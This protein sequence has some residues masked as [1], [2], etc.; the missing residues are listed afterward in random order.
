MSV[1]Y[2]AVPENYQ[3]SSMDMGL[4]L[5]IPLALLGG[6]ML[7]KG[8]ITAG[9]KLLGK[10]ADKA[11]GVLKGQTRNVTRMTEKELAEEAARQAQWDAALAQSPRPDLAQSRLNQ[12]SMGAPNPAFVGSGGTVVKKPDIPKA[13]KKEVVPDAPAS[14]ADVSVVSPG[15]SASPDTQ[16]LTKNTSQA[17]R[18]SGSQARNQKPAPPQGE[19]VPGPVNAAWKPE[20]QAVGQPFEHYSMARI[21][22]LGSA[23]DSPHLYTGGNLTKGLD[24]TVGVPGI[25]PPPQKSLNLPNTGAPAA[26]QIPQ[27]P[28]AQVNTNQA[29]A[30]QQ[31][32]LQQ[33]GVASV[34]QQ[35][36]TPG[37][38]SQVSDAMQSQNLG[39]MSYSRIQNQ[40]VKSN[41]D[42]GLPEQSSTMHKTSAPSIKIPTPGGGSMPKLKLPSVKQQSA[43]KG[44]NLP[45][46]ST[47]QPSIPNQGGMGGAAQ[48]GSFQIPAAVPQQQMNQITQ[49]PQPQV[50]MPKTA[51]DLGAELLSVFTKERRKRRKRKMQDYLR[52]MA[53]DETLQKAAA[54][55]GI[56][57][58]TGPWMSDDGNVISMPVPDAMLYGREPNPLTEDAQTRIRRI[59]TVE[60]PRDRLTA[61][62][63][64]VARPRAGLWTDKLMND[65]F[66]KNP[67]QDPIP[68]EAGSSAPYSVDQGMQ[69][70]GSSP[71]P[72]QTGYF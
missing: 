23:T 62:N 26:N 18:V 19:T 33:S 16:N 45:N 50:P 6:T 5:G 56:R 60:A 24:N 70:A 51:S 40:A 39:T 59:G 52:K 57:G 68:P 36:K 67:T 25:D 46:Q 14:K 29:V 44:L 34:G 1:D 30:V 3:G 42:Q 13:P 58:N 31:K 2:S 55:Y 48:A 41:M 37:A 21:Q 7:G 69:S 27:A 22:Q 17:Q 54:M 10:G 66:L 53:G 12:Q 64:N 28:K 43:P 38:Q 32:P 8:L 72:V 35:V 65:T 9:G 11:K 20:P 61:P 49:M 71:V 4:Q 15:P 47:F 63:T